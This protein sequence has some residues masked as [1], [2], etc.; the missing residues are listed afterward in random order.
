M[1]KK[2][3]IVKS[4]M[5][6]REVLDSRGNPTVEVEIA[7]SKG[8]ARAIVPAGA[9]KGIYEAKEL[10]DG[11]KRY[12]G[13]GVGKAVRNAALLGKKIEYLHYDEREKIL[14]KEKN[15]IGANASLALSMAL[16]RR[17][18][19]IKHIPLYQHIGEIYK[20][21]RFAMPIPSMNVINGGKH[22][23]NNLAFQEF[24]LYPNGAKSF[25]DALRMN[26][27]T[28][29]TLKEV[30]T[31]KYGKAATN[32]G[33]EGGFAPPLSS[34]DEAL[35]LLV[36]AIEKAGYRK[37]ISLA[38]D[39][40][41]SEFYRKGKYFC[42]RKEYFGM[43]LIDKYKEIVKRYPIVSIEDPFSQDDF[44][45]FYVLKKELKRV[46]IVGDDLLVTN[47]ERISKA[48][49]EEACDA[50]LLKVNQIG[51][52]SEALHAARLSEENGWGI[53]VSH[54]SGETEDTFISHLSVGIGAGQIKAGAP[55]RG[56]RTAKYNELLRI[57]EK[58]GKK[59]RYGPK[60]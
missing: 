41:S 44:A 43:E 1:T 46:Q 21:K 7:T 48:L 11:G 53:M 16:I 37:K 52:I 30:I 35:N 42:D 6:S 31:K 20:N 27:E 55:A 26:V 58:L 22:A 49:I 12:L 32:V 9:S 54:R 45:N 59:A 24:M 34:S 60:R 18:A 5:K 15:K 28:Y 23:G 51:T 13:L 2:R 40:A 8:V 19:M 10:R 57:E 56:E 25:S 29:H 14:A 36:D 3:C 50:L 47:P 38:M 33:D 4:Y 39:A 17:D